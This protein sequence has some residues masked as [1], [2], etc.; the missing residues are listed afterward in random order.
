MKRLTL[1]LLLLSCDT[2][3]T[4]PKGACIISYTYDEY[5][6]AA[7]VFLPKTNHFCER[8]KKSECKKEEGEFH[9]GDSCQEHGFNI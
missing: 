3:P 6:A 9:T 2:E 8:L 4:N 1:L 5:F 7:D